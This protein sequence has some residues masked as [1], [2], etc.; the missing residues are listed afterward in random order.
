MKAIKNLGSKIALIVT[1]LSLIGLIGLEIYAS[2]TTDK[3]FQEGISKIDSTFKAK[4]DSV[5]NLYI[6]QKNSLDQEHS[7][8]INNYL[9]NNASYSIALPSGR[10]IYW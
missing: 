1:G 9:K 10:A 3:E 8:E 4:Q 6:K 2:K 5:Y 7:E